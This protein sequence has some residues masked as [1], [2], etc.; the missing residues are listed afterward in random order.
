MKDKTRKIIGWI[1]S[2]LV[3]AFMLMGAI[4]K[5]FPGY[6]AALIK[7]SANI[8]MVPAWILGLVIILGVVLYLVPRTQVIGFVLT[9]TYLGGALVITWNDMGFTPAIAL[10]VALVFLWSGQALLRPSLLRRSDE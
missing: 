4:P 9:S 6:Q 8:G 3:M 1:L 7:M 5:F 2:G 10:I